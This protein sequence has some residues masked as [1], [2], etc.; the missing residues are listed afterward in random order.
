MYRWWA[1]RPW[2]T[3]SLLLLAIALAAISLARWEAILSY[4]GDYLV[5]VED[6]KPADLI[7]VLAG[8][9]WGPR[10]LKGADLAVQGYAPLAL[11]SGTPYQGRM[12]GE[13]AIEFLAKRGYPT[14][15]FQSFGHHSTS[16]IA[17]AMVLRPE[18][19]RRKVKRVL[20][21]TSSYHSRRASMVFRLFC[22][23]IDFIAIPAPDPQ[24]RPRDWWKDASSRR[25]FFAEWSKII[26]T[27]VFV[28]P[29]Y[30]FQS[31]IGYRRAS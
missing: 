14:R 11:F 31:M 2:F 28:Y 26:G 19:T 13:M 22:P 8:D 18:L 23:G 6:P 20:L 16:T 17:E 27:L 15:S 12:D 30:R 9:F 21:V 24:Y 5:A 4:L 1:K 10:V 29:M 25:F 3:R 7:L